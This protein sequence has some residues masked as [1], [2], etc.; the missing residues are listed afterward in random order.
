MIHY[1]V[2]GGEYSDYH[3]KAAFFDKEKAEGYTKIFGGEV[4]EWPDCMEIP[5]P[6]WWIATLEPD[7]K[8]FTEKLHTCEHVQSSYD[9]LNWKSLSYVMCYGETKEE[10]IKNATDIMAKAKAHFAGI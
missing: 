6:L 7:G 9:F 5:R 3:I 4:E 2:T 8:I 1:I 10:A